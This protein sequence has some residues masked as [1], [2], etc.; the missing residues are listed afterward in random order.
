MKK[1]Q[2]RSYISVESKRM[3]REIVGEGERDK[4][5]RRGN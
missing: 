5:E 1:L 3:R 2:A 4:E